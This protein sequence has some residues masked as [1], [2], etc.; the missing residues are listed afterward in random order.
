MTQTKT[1]NQ[2]LIESLKNPT[3]ATAYLWAI[4][5]EENTEPE[6]LKVALENILEAL[7]ETQLSPH[8]IQL[9]KKKIDDL[10]NQSGSEVIYSLVAWLNKLGL[11]LT[12]SISE[13]S[14]LVDQQE[15][16]DNINNRQQFQILP[17]KSKKPK[18]K[19]GSAKGLIEISDD[20]DDPL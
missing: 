13:D 8:E 15:S 10:L 18:P 14:P 16:Q 3:E 17:L 4:L 5:Q 1:Y 12:V 19:F 11:E 9:H 6:L 7:G 20:F 2:Y